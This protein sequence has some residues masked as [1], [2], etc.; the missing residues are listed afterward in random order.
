MRNSL[1]TLK[2]ALL[3]IAGVFVVVVVAALLA[4][5]LPPKQHSDNL[6]DLNHLEHAPE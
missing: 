6:A 2:D 4:W 5:A 3:A 1:S